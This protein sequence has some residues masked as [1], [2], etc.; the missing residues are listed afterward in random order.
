MSIVKAYYV[1]F[2]PKIKA[3]LIAASV[4]NDSTANLALEPEIIEYPPGD[5]YCLIT[6][7]AGDV[8]QGGVAG[9][10]NEAMIITFNFSTHLWFL[11]ALDEPP[12]D[13]AVLTKASSPMGIYA[14]CDDMVDA[15]QMFFPCS[16]GETG[17]LAEPM[18]LLRISNP[19]R[20]ERNKEFSKIEMVW[21]AKI[22]QLVGNTYQ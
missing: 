16:I 9:G 11:N 21:E 13:E 12:R 10:G 6:P 2:L 15:L 22:W 3:R 20:D 19:K 4:F 8:F 18:R 17:M 5:I 1:D 7:G 14:K